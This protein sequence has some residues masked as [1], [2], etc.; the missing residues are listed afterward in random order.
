MSDG[1]GGTQVLDLGFVGF[2]RLCATTG[3]PDDVSLV[4]VMIF[5][6]GL[7]HKKRFGGAWATIQVGGSL[8]LGVHRELDS[9]RG[10]GDSGRGGPGGG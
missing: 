8:V 2:R 4:V 3:V 5:S 10:G 6:W 7:H 1:H 9:T